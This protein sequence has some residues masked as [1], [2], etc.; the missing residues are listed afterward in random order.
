M[1]IGVSAYK[2]CSSTFRLK[3]EI[4]D[5][6]RDKWNP[7]LERFSLQ[8]AKYVYQY[9]ELDSSI[10]EIRLIKLT[11]HPIT[12]ISCSLERFPLEIAPKYEAISY[13][14]GSS[15]KGH[16][17]SLGRSWLPITRNVYK[18]L[19]DRGSYFRTRWLW[20]DAVCINQ[21]DNVEKG[22]QV[23]IMGDIYQSAERVLVWLGDTVVRSSDITSAMFLLERLNYNINNYEDYKQRLDS[24]KLVTGSR[25][26]WDALGR[27]LSHYYWQ[28]TWIIQEIAKAQKVHILYGGQYISWDIFSLLVSQLGF[29]P[30]NKIIADEL[31]IFKNDSVAIIGG[32]SQVSLI[33]AV[34]EP[35]TQGKLLT[36]EESLALTYRC[37]ATDARDKV[38][39]LTNL[40][41]L[42][43]IDEKTNVRP[44]YTLTVQE[45][46]IRAARY[47]LSNNSSFLLLQS[48][49]GHERK[50][51][52]LPSWVPD[53]SALRPQMHQVDSHLGNGD[54][55]SG[56][57]SLLSPRFTLSANLLEISVQGVTISK[58]KHISATSCCFDGSSEAG[59]QGVQ[60]F[61]QAAH[62]IATTHLPN[63]YTLTNQS[64]A[65]AFWRTLIADRHPSND[66]QRGKPVSLEWPA[67]AEYGEYFKIWRDGMLGLDESAVQLSD[68]EGLRV[69][70]ASFA[71]SRAL[72]NACRD[73]RKFAVTED[74]MIGLVPPLTEVG[75]EVCI[76]ADAAKPVLLRMGNTERGTYLLV[77][78]CYMHG[79]IDGKSWSNGTGYRAWTIC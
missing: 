67:Q 37:L 53:W 8:P 26:S 52:G 30:G 20:I 25:E 7:V 62:L 58:I 13:T 74:G 11:K 64:L 43:D 48:G 79:I 1:Q 17:V 54:Q 59:R 14:W 4:I 49:I 24:M 42:T 60:P 15:T 10:Q 39:A 27:L 69:K 75:D 36:L 21:D 34:R 2:F 28:R 51:D 35:L 65:E 41:E 70:N 3:K 32:V 12:G 29:E 22:I 73:S 72:G 9:E 6:L 33:S 61:Y 50:V 68:E 77:G 16:L 45:V 76:L 56:R 55:P 38:F 63:M 23:N 40:T 5:H 71:Y 78:D 18:I 31:V 47:M 66:Q 44:D 57:G 46:Y 19:Q